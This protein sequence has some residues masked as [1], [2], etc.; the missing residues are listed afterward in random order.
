MSVAKSSDAAKKRFIWHKVTL[1]EL[2]S[3]L[4]GFLLMSP[5][6]TNGL[7]LSLLKEPFVK[8]ASATDES[9]ESFVVRRFG[10]SVSD[11][12]VS[13]V[14]HGIYAGD[15]STLSVRSTMRFL[16]DMEHKYGSVVG[17][18][19]S[20]LFSSNE[21]DRIVSLL[22][23]A[24][25]E[26]KFIRNIKDTASIYSFKNGLQTLTDCLYDTLKNDGVEFINSSCTGLTYGNNLVN[27]KKMQSYSSLSAV[28]D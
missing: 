13:A 15:I 18:I 26:F 8:K 28:Y 12:L 5:P 14:V 20:S 16:W 2:P 17:G 3:T 6:V 1:N 23:D 4:M 21:S 27:V 10:R 22:D 25:E 19:V 7:I 24:S 11:N 9:I